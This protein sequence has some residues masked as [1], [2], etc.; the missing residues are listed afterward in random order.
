[1]FSFGDY[2]D[3][4][5]MGFRSLRVINEDWIAPGGGF[6]L[7]PHRDMEIVTVILDGALEHR[8]SIGNGSV[9]R[10]GEIQKMSAGT[11][12]VHSEVNASAQEPVHLLQIW[13]TPQLRGVKPEY[14]QTRL[15]PGRGLILAASPKGPITIQRDA[16]IY[17][18]RGAADFAPRHAWIQIT[19]GPISVNKVDLQVGDGAAVLG[20]GTL[21]IEGD[22][23]YLIF[24]LG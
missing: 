7:H 8:D 20:E 10:S 9:I 13:I 4:D 19:H 23:E 12:I 11:G 18:G 16:S 1:M 24:D 21:R 22:G 3:P 2:H 5:H 14:Q 6:P 15:D 17:L